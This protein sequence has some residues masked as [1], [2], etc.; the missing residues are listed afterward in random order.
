[1]LDEPI[2]DSN[3]LWEKQTL[4]KEIL[5]SI[6]AQN[7]II[8]IS[9]YRYLLLNLKDWSVNHFKSTKSKTPGFLKHDKNRVCACVTILQCAFTAV[10]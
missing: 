3:F 4:R 6:S 9:T 1:M 7:I 5:G 8:I 2:E 10:S